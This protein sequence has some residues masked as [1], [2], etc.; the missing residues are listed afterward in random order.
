M[1]YRVIPAPPHRCTHLFSVG[2]TDFK[3]CISRDLHLGVTEKTR[4]LPSGPM[5]H[6]GHCVSLAKPKNA[7]VAAVSIYI[8]KLRSKIVSSYS[9]LIYFVL[10]IEF[11]FILTCTFSDTP[12]NILQKHLTIIANLKCN[13]LYAFSGF[14]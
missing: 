6:N 5:T 12:L 3:C 9:L 11:F 7:L 8:Q 2:K 4:L 13:F 10:E 1:P 14:R